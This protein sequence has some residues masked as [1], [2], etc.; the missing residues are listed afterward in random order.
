M[1]REKEYCYK[2]SQRYLDEEEDIVS[3][4]DNLK[5]ALKDLYYFLYIDFDY[6]LKES[7]F[8]KKIKREDAKYKHENLFRL[9]ISG[10]Y[11]TFVIIE[12]CTLNK[13]FYSDED[14]KNYLK[15]EKEESESEE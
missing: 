5:N 15:E 6:T 7:K 8:I 3:V 10:D 11:I 12:K 2:I 13:A 9:E 14:F 1:K 4:H